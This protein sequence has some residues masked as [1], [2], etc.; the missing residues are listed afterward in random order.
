MT[1]LPVESVSLS[2]DGVGAG[3]APD[4]AIPRRQGGGLEFPCARAYFAAVR[5]V[6][7]TSFCSGTR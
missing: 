3:P 1:R 4:M 6:I 5:A 2:A 7:R